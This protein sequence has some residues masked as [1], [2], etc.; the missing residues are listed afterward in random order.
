MA[1]L[2]NNIIRSARLVTKYF[3]PSSLPIADI[4]KNNSNSSNNLIM[5]ENNQKYAIVADNDSI[6]KPDIDDRNYRMIKLDNELVALLIN[7]PATDKSAAALDVNVGSFNDPRDLPGLAHF[8][9]HLLFLGTEKYPKENDYNSYLS[10]NSGY[11]NA[12]TSSL[13]TNYY[14]EIKNDALHGALD[15]F[16]QFFIKPL[17]SPSGKD[18]EINAVDSENKKNLQS[19]TWRLYQLAKSTTSASHPFN[20]F[21]TGNKTTLGDI[22]I[23]KNMNVRDELIKF[24]R[25]N[26]SSN[27]MC[28][29]IL[30]NESLDTLTN[31]TVEMFSNVENKSLPKPIYTCSPFQSDKYLNQLYKVKPIRQMR[32]LQL[33]FPIPSTAQYWEYLPTRYISHLLGHESKGSLLYNFKLK[34]WAN[35]LSSGASEISPGF[36]E[37]NINIELTVEGL[38]KYDS[39]IE[40]VFRYIEMLK[41]EGPKEWIFEELHKESLNSFKFKQ[42]SAVASTVSRFA[43]QL[44]DLEYY[45]IPMKNPILN[46]DQNTVARGTIPPPDF[47]SLSISR[48]YDPSLINDL[49]SYLKP[50]N[51]RIFLI[52]NEIF[53]ELNPDKI[54]NEKWYNTEYTSEAYGKLDSLKKLGL[55]PNLTLPD[56]N[57]FIATNFDLAKTPETKFPKLVELDQ[58]SK[59]WFKSNTSLSGPR[60]TITIKFNLPGSTS[61][62]LN[63]LYLSLFVELLDD[64]L[65]SL[66]YYAS[67]AGLNYSFNIARE[68]ISL[69]I[70]GYS[71]KQEI[72]LKK[73]IETLDKFTSN[74]SAWDKKREQRFNILKEK[75]FRSLKNFGFS[76]P[77]QQVGPII[78]SLLNEN[79]W[80]IDDE[81]SCCDAVDY[82]SLKNYSINLFKICFIEVLAIGNFEKGDSINIYNAIKENLPT[83]SGSITLTGSQFT[84]GRSLNL[85][86]N[87]VSHFIRANDDPEN[88][89]SCIESFIQIGVI[90]QSRERV[91]NELVSQILHEPCFNRL[92]TLE[93]LGYVVFSGTRETRTT[94]GLRFL[95]QSEYPT[96]YLLMR[97]DQFIAKM[98]RYLQNKMTNEDFQKHVEALIN[99]KEQKMKNLREEENFTWNRIASGYYDFD[100]R[101]KDIDLLKNL[102]LEEVVRFYNDKILGSHSNS[103]LIVHLQSQKVPKLDTVKMLK[104]SVSNF[105]YSKDEFDCVNFESE[106]VNEK[107]DQFFVDKEIDGDTLQEL[108]KDEIFEG[109]SYKDQLADEILYNLSHNW[110]SLS[111]DEEELIGVVG[112][113]KCSV[114]LT[115]APTAKIMK[116]HYDDD[117]CFRGKL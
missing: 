53:D 48:K 69:Q 52:S 67:L 38:K 4:K 100:R 81:I 59:V 71:D 84:R 113:W 39:V 34:G 37:F 57:E 83:L 110:N 72:L 85:E 82:E 73:L 33:T 76:T 54:Q 61:T 58:Y 79:S 106:K 114:P 32:N 93:Q 26:Y 25:E 6:V 28:L 1:F 60:S 96:F 64:E 29:S 89:N 115:A 50:E 75:L 11:S 40:D 111:D 99:K 91:I 44:Q 107:I 62:P 103:R 27:I 14:F 86:N 95:I 70:Y 20:G 17:F 92:R 112:E 24:H 109:F 78:S 15:R 8:C 23:E 13:H 41:A 35:D 88:I 55:D 16:S 63:S 45:S 2:T 65:N 51:M 36:S 97:I 80:L 68:G 105:I 98:G 94:F 7:D 3:R 22:P 30:S 101:G 77:Y 49:L 19:D 90:S 21:S 42:K 66:S 117:L 47:L 18:R 56:R 46:I 5:T 116:V 102:T 104:N 108:F 87:P 10:K 9:E 43:G 74:D 12:F 31:W